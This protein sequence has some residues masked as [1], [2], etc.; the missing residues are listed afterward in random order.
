MDLLVMR[1]SF[2][3]IQGSVSKM[4]SNT[5]LAKCWALSLGKELL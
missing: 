3:I 2:S 4:L 5:L 1:D